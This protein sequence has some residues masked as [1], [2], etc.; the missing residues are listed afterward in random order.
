ML[1]LPITSYNVRG[2]EDDPGRAEARGGWGGGM[3]EDDA[4]RMIGGPRGDD[5]SWLIPGDTSTSTSTVCCPRM[6]ILQPTANNG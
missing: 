4:D 6:D 2:R 3:A 5:A 1:P